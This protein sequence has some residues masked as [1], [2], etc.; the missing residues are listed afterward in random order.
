MNEGW[1]WLAL[2]L[3][4]LVA[5]VINTLAGG[6][7]LLTVPTLV[8]FGLPATIAN[9]TNRVG[10]LLQNVF[11]TRSFRR[12][13]FDALA[14]SLPIVMPAVVGSILGATVASRL[15]SAIFERIFGVA[16]IVLL[17][18]ILRG[19]KPKPRPDARP[20]PPRPPLLNAALFFAIGFYGGS[21]QAGVGIFVIAA[22]ARSGVDLIRANAIKVI[23]VGALT[24]VALPVFILHHQVH[25]PYA[26]A[27]ATGFSLGG[28]LG[29]RFAARGGERVIKPVLALS[30]LALAGK[31]LGLY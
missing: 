20:A 17:V 30:V 14:E 11:A 9:G 4:G 8:Y 7:T 3:A 29:A 5:G 16:M 18:P 27:T 24:L 25:W 10:V 21:I 19:T 31:M 13:G 12:E 23:L 22:L 6:G 28:E 1:T 2:A 15:S 26:I